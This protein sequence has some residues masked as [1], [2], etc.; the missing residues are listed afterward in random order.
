MAARRAGLF[1]LRRIP[2]HVRLRSAHGVRSDPPLPVKDP[3]IPVTD[4]RLPVTDPRLPVS[5]ASD[6]VHHIVW[7]KQWTA[8][9]WIA[10]RR[11]SLRCAL[12]QCAQP[13]P[14]PQPP[15]PPGAAVRG[16]GEA[17]PPAPTAA[18]IDN[19]RIE[20]RWPS[21]HGAGA[22]ASLIDRR[23][24]N[25]ESH[26][27]QRYSYNGMRAIVVRSSSPTRLGRTTTTVPGFRATGPT[28]SINLATSITYT[29]SYDR[30]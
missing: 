28:G 13:Q 12:A 26:V 23:A 14:D 10:A 3:R 20:S 11:V 22:L 25:V 16:A 15:P 18:N 8:A 2:R 4:P 29:C 24:S 7:A 30:E 9:A 5:G 17:D 27:R 21:G 6:R 1:C 19:S